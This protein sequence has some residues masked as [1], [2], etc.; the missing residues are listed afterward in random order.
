MSSSDRQSKSS[1]YATFIESGLGKTLFSRIKRKVL[2]LF[3]LNPDERFYFRETARLL[4]D[5]P[6]S[7][8]TELK[9]LHAAGILDMEKIG[10]QKFYRANTDC[11]IYHELRS[12]VVKTFG[13][14]DR[15][16]DTLTRHSAEI[17]LAWIHGSIVTGEDTGRSDIDLI[18]IGTL[19]FR[20]LVTILSPL[21][22]SLG[23]QLN[24]SLY[25]VDEFASKYRDEN[26]F[27][28][29]VVTAEKLFMVGGQDDLDR[30]VSK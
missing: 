20:K 15:L 11:P 5:S 17:D 1:E 24:P 14:A 27:V 4:N 9:T 26:H 3:L 12:I 30:M 23:R 7:V 10:V 28:R 2:S 6:G 21:E 18:V 16:R 29:T 8:H 25:S 22:E 19:G 13:I